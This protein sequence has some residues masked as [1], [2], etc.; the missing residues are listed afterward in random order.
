MTDIRINDLHRPVQTPAMK[1]LITEFAQADFSLDKQT[2][3]KLAEE[4]LDV[5]IDIDDDLIDRFHLALDEARINGTVHGY[6]SFYMQ[7]IIVNAIVQTSRLN[8][9]HR[10]FPQIADAQIAPPLIVAGMPRTGTTYLLQLISSDPSLLS[11]KR[12]EVHFPFPSSAVIEGGAP[13]TREQDAVALESMEGELVPLLSSLYDVDAQAATEEIEVMKYGGYSCAL[14]FYGDTPSYDHFL[15]SRSQ[16]DG[17]AYLYRFLQAL[18]YFKGA[19]PSQRW[20]LKSPQHLGALDAVN[21]TFPQASLVFTHRDPASV[22]A[23]LLTLTGYTARMVYSDISKERLLDRT[24]RMQHGFLRGLVK[25][26]DLFEGRCTHVYF[27]DLMNDYRS[28]VEQIYAASG[29]SYDSETQARIEGQAAIFTR[30]RRA[31]RVIYDL[32]GDFG[33]TRDQVREEFSY[34]LDKFPAA[35]EEQHQ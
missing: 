16:S 5:P 11:L 6:G 21:D 28:S 17:Y 31:G 12:W 18:Q 30:G 13:D 20:L 24:R 19:T 9:L 3:L 25:H 10:R 33:L 22:F 14:S 1:K 2:V 23:S 29:L 34:Y 15:Y 27:N 4:Q 26:A 32:E 35:I 7:Q 8:D